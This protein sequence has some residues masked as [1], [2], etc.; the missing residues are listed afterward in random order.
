MKGTNE[1]PEEKGVTLRELLLSLIDDEERGY[2]FLRALSKEDKATIVEKIVTIR[3]NNLPIREFMRIQGHSLSMLE[4]MYVKEE[5]TGDLC[6][7]IARAIDYA[8]IFVGCC[9]EEQEEML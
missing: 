8:C 5:T 1:K 3:N 6:K 7:D 9:S 4:S 2:N